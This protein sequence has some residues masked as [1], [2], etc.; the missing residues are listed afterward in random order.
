[1]PEIS[2]L[3]SAAFGYNTWAARVSSPEILKNILHDPAFRLI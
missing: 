2:C 3:Y 1:M